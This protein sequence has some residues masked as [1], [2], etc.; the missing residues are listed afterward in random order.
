MQEPFG[1][2]TPDELFLYQAEMAPIDDIERIEKHLLLC[3]Q[4]REAVER[5]EKEHP[6]PGALDLYAIGRLNGPI[7]NGIK[8]H[9]SHCQWCSET[10]AARSEKVAQ[11][12]KGLD[13]LIGQGAASQPEHA[14]LASQLTST[15]EPEPEPQA[16][17]EPEQFISIPELSQPEPQKAA[18]HQPPPDPPRPQ[19]TQFDVMSLNEP[20]PVAKAAP[21]SPPPPQDEP[22]PPPPPPTGDERAVHGMSGF[23]FYSLGR[24]LGAVQSLAATA[25]AGRSFQTLSEAYD[26]LHDLLDEK[27]LPLATTAPVAHELSRILRE[28]IVLASDEGV[29]STL[30]PDRLKT[31]VRRFENALEDD[32]ERMGPLPLESKATEELQTLVE[33]PESSFPPQMWSSLSPAAQHHWSEATRCLAY[34]LPTATAFHALRTLESVVNLYLE[35]AGVASQ[36]R[37][38]Q[39]GLELLRDRGA[40]PKAVELALHLTSLHCNPLQ[41]ADCFVSPEEGV[42][43]FDLC[44][45][46]IKAFL[47]DMERRQFPTLRK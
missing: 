44:T 38:L 46:A 10:L 22:P 8:L 5:I 25:S 27:G 21:A 37:S 2:P 13:I 26:A 14:E 24:K 32:L 30:N 3:R 47:R 36:P 15:P 31:A 43:Q 45:I 7:G 17:P 18:Q 34:G 40:N 39:E 29:A 11:V 9:L 4:C 23:A 41:R 33:H 12:R 28:A 1:H 20:P 6:E 42:D 16:A 19:K 35:H